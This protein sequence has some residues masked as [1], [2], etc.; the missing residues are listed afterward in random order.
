MASVKTHCSF[1]SL[2]IM[3]Y[4]YLFLIILLCL[5]ISGCVQTQK[6]N[7]SN[8]TES[9][10]NETKIDQSNQ[11]N[12]IE[13]KYVKNESVVNNKS[14]TIAKAVYEKE[15]KIEALFKFDGELY[16]H[17]Y[18]RIYKFENNTWN[19]LGFWNFEG[20][21]YIGY[22]AIPSC[23]KYDASEISS[24]LINWDQKIIQES[25]PVLSDKN[26]TKIQVDIGKYKI[27][28]VYGD[29]FVCTDGID[30]EFL[31]KEKGS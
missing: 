12:I 27:R 14:L 11:T 3:F 10:S 4:K 31:I 24:L 9:V 18:I 13:V 5:L 17:P 7:K 19:F 1:R 30:A 28:V 15:E 23:S 26:I 25:R 21:Q 22:G 2:A 8:L 29:Q 6:N 16:I 20:A